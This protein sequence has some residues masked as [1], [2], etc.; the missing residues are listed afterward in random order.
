MTRPDRLASPTRAVVS[1]K[2]MR[3]P[4]SR[5]RTQNGTTRLAPEATTTAGRTERSSRIAPTRFGSTLTGL[6]PYSGSRSTRSPR[7]SRSS[8]CGPGDVTQ[9]RGASSCGPTTASRSRWPPGEPARTVTSR[10]RIA[11][12]RRAELAGQRGGVD[13]GLLLRRAVPRE[14]VEALDRRGA[15]ALQQR[16]VAVEL[17]QV[18]G[19]RVDVARRVDEPRPRV[20][21]AGPG[22]VGYREDAAARLRLV[23][24]ERAALLDRRQ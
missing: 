7:R 23:G 12:P 19:E 18:G 1:M 21:A 8:A 6:R 22:R 20:L 13:A 16:R 14:V 17:A 3:A 5:A 2:T 9:T 24:H 10:D 11:S 4:V 15:Q